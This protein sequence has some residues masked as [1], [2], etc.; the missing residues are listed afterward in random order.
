MLR[1]LFKLEVYTSEMV[2][3]IQRISC[4]RRL[5]NYHMISSYYYMYLQEWH[6]QVV[7]IKV[8]IQCIYMY[9]E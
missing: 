2:N 1:Y 9:V 7:P 6:E 3:S 8:Y 4:L 5:T